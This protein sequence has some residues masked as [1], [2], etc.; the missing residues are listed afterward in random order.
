MTYVCR[1]NDET[2]QV[3]DYTDQE[4]LQVTM[5]G[6]QLGSF[7]WKMSK[8]MSKTLLGLMEKA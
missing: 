6:P 8:K 5:N 4:A 3:G 1:F 7:K 2:M